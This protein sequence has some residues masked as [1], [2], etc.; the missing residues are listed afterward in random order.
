M[1]DKI[2]WTVSDVTVDDLYESLGKL[3]EIGWGSRMIEFHTSRSH[4]GRSITM[5]LSEQEKPDRHGAGHEKGT[6]K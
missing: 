2:D 5:T 1:A 4:L 6:P 3:R